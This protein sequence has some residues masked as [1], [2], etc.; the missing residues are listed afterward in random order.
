LDSTQALPV[1]SIGFQ[2][3]ALHTHP[4]VRDAI[5]TIILEF[6]DLRK[7]MLKKVQ[8]K[9]AESEASFAHSDT[10]GLWDSAKPFLAANS[11]FLPAMLQELVSMTVYKV[12]CGASIGETLQLS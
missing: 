9:N 1:L 12:S 7:T 10:G 3:D 2:I 11:A 8:Q 6:P 5:T 4:E